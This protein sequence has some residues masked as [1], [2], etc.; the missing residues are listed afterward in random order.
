MLPPFP[1]KCRFRTSRELLVAKTQECNPFL[2]LRRTGNKQNGKVGLPGLGDQE[3]AAGVG[4]RRLAVQDFGV[5][6]TMPS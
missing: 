6:K 5:R 3:Q 1:L 4:K 2:P